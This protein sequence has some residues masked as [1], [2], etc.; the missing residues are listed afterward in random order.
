VIDPRGEYEDVGAVGVRGE[1]VD[2]DLLEPGF[3]GNQGSVD[4][5]HS[6]SRSFTN[7]HKSNR[8]PADAGGRLAVGLHHWAALCA[9]GGHVRIDDAS[10]AHCRI[11][12]A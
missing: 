10:V 8:P 7:V 1:D 9:F 11:E 4:L 5:G 3:I 12:G 2:D 6:A